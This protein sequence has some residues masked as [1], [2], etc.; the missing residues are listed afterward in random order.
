[1]TRSLD[2]LVLENGPGS[3]REAIEALEAAGHRV[4]RCHEPGE[5]PFPCRAIDD[6][7]ACP[8]H[9]NI[10]VALL[11]R[12]HVHP[13]PSPLEDGVACAIR[14]GIPLVE[15]GP[16]ILDPYEPYVTLRMD[17]GS[18]RS[19]VEVCEEA[20]AIAQRPLADDI[21]R[22]CALVFVGAGIDPETVQCRMEP[23]GRRTLVHLDVPGPVTKG[24]RGA[25]ALRA[26]DAVRDSPHPRG[27]VNV[28]VHEVSA[29]AAV[30]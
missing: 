12:H 14:A 26:L 20:V 18:A 29:L 4:H 27:A 15:E 10:D 17:S 24:V 8:L 25:L 7:T 21:L 19:V 11:V 22:R 23:A 9:G 5:E 6:P 16:G 28:R 13:Q 1:M 3:A 30:D 2:V